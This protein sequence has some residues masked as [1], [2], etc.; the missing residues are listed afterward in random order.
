M[1]KE[2]KSPRETRP[3]GRM[4]SITAEAGSLH[5]CCPSE[6]EGYK[7]RWVGT[8]GGSLINAPEE[9]I[10]L[11][12]ESSSSQHPKPALQRKAGSR[13]IFSSGVV[14]YSPVY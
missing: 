1:Q 2:V 13:F 6:P 4:H 5:A 11:L 8:D 14:G 3:I 12:G 10:T 7:I 9:N